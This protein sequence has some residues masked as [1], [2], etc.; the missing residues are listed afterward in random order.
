MSDG[1]FNTLMEVVQI[2]DLIDLF[3]GSGTGGTLF[4]PTDEAFADLS[5]GFLD[6]QKADPQAQWL[7]LEL[8][9]GNTLGVQLD[10]TFVAGES[11]TTTFNQFTY[12]V[13]TDATGKVVLNGTA[14][15]IDPNLQASN[16]II[17]AVDAVLLPPD[18][19]ETRR[20]RINS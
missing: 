9:L 8:V 18:Y 5:E 10:S 17:H 14:T 13:E 20:A 2:A 7:L 11:S 6:N 4:A 3:E 16:G 1:R 15:I 19:L 12:T